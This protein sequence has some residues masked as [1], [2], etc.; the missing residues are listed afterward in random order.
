[1]TNR[2]IRKNEYNIYRHYNNPPFNS[3]QELNPQKSPE[4]ISSGLVF[5]KTVTFI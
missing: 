1:M 2:I 4:N 5:I 3:L